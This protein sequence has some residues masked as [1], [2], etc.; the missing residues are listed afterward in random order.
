MP[1]LLGQSVNH[2]IHH[3]P[4]HSRQLPI[5]PA[6]LTELYVNEV[7]QQEAN[8][9]RPT[10]KAASSSCCIPR[11]LSSAATPDRSQDPAPKQQ[12]SW[13]RRKKRGAQGRSQETWVVMCIC[14]ELKLCDLIKSLPF[15]RFLFPQLR[16]VRFILGSL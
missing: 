6:C 5:W 1:D 12:N 15:A 11:L 7:F 4:T 14:L 2:T 16:T 8:G 13:R 9:V 10:Q 3:L